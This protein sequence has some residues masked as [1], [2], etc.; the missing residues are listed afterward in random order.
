MVG[1]QNMY[2]QQIKDIAM[3][4]PSL[5]SATS[6]LNRDLDDYQIILNETLSSL[7]SS[8]FIFCPY[9]ESGHWV[10]F[11][12]CMKKREIYIFDSMPVEERKTIFNKHLDEALHI[13]DNFQDRQQWGGGQY[14]YLMAVCGKQRGLVECGYF[15][16]RFMHD[17]VQHYCQSANLVQD[18]I[19]YEP[20]TDAELIEV[21]DIFAKYVLPFT[22][23]R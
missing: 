5:I 21:I 16:M 1:L 11:V 12:I 8:Q 9:F 6:W 18:F 14:K 23:N 20:Y 7:V 10:L 13:C 2:P 3:I 4:S 15:V 19:R 17:I 22:F